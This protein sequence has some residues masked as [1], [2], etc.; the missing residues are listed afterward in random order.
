MDFTLDDLRKHFDVKKEEA[1]LLFV[2]LTL[3]PPGNS[4]SFLNGRID[5][6]NEDTCGLVIDKS[7]YHTIAE[8]FLVQE[9]DAYSELFG[10]SDE[11]ESD[12]S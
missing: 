6:L 8:D 7:T 12:D 1:A 9:T 2:F 10:E 4:V 5:K 11:E 3:L